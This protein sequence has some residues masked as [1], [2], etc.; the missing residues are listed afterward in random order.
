MADTQGNNDLRR[1][2]DKRLS[3]KNKFLII[4]KYYEENKDKNLN[5]ETVATQLEAYPIIKYIQL[6]MEDTTTVKQMNDDEVMEITKFIDRL[7]DI[8]RQGEKTET[9]NDEGIEVQDLTNKQMKNLL[10]IQFDKKQDQPSTWYDV[11]DMPIYHMIIV[12]INGLKNK[13]EKNIGAQTVDLIEELLEETEEDIGSPDEISPGFELAKIKFTNIAERTRVFNFIKR[14]KPEWNTTIPPLHD[15]QIKIMNVKFTPD[16]IKQWIER[17]FIKNKWKKCWNVA[18]KHFYKTNNNFDVIIE[19]DPGLRE[20][21]EQRNGLISMG[22][23]KVT[24]IDYFDV[25]QCKN[26]TKFGHMSNKCNQISICPYCGDVNH[27]NGNC[28]IKNL[29]HKWKCPNCNQYG[30]SAFD[31]KCPKFRERLN[32]ELEKKNYRYKIIMA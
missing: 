9:G 14:V 16:N 1:L 29:P 28:P 11:S 25:R 17:L 30:Q 6:M 12:K 7:M 15:P 23:K 5:K 13:W 10:S 31:T 2:K 4:K 26:C 3:N 20:W 19:V 21:I 24:V 22:Y 8:E 27:Q 18:I 32:F